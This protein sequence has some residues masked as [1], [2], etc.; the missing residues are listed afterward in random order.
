MGYVLKA[1]KKFAIKEEVTEGTYVAPNAG[2]DFIKAQEANVEVTKEI[3]ERA[4]IGSSI[5]QHKPEV[6]M[7]NASGSVKFEMKAHGTEGAAPEYGLLF[8]S[9]LG[10]ERS[11]VTK[12]ASDEDYVA[13]DYS[14]TK[15]CLANAD[16]N[17]YAV[18]DIVVTKQ[19]ENYHCS[20]I[21]SI[22]N[23]DDGVH[24]T[25]LIASS[26][27]YADGDTIAAVQT[28]YCAD[29][30]HPSFSASQ[31]QEEA[32]LKKAVGC[33]VK[34]IALEGFGTGTHAAFN[35]AFD[36]MD[37]DEEVT[38]QP[39]TEAYDSALPPIV[40]GAKI[41]QDGVEIDCNE[42]SFSIENEL[43]VQKATGQAN[44]KLGIRVTKRTIKGSINPYKE[45]D[46]V[47]NYTKFD[48]GTEFSIFAFAKV[49][50]GVTGEYEDVVAVYLPQCSIA[51]LAEGD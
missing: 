47:A 40:L 24:I 32:I 3:L 5:G 28:Y 39:V 9:C 19:S 15:I 42:F 49:P 29:S 16:K 38:A 17:I 11:A 6:G 51:N 33:K 10:A 22:G 8:E 45:D 20:P 37:G 23:D 2:A 4:Y 18:G 14:T 44:G 26:E 25:L 27:T 12:D 41:Y 50:T 43:S 21:A 7:S 34:S 30:G 31:Y 48:A 36:A 35:V 1:N 46:S 13:P